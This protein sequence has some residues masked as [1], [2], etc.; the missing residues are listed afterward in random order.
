[1]LLRHAHLHNDKV[2]VVDFVYPVLKNHLP[3]VQQAHA[4]L[5]SRLVGVPVAVPFHKE[6]VSPLNGCDSLVHVV[7]HFKWQAVCFVPEEVLQRFRQLLML[8][9]SCRHL[10]H[11]KAAVNLCLHQLRHNVSHAACLCCA[12]AFRVWHLVNLS[13]PVVK[14]GSLVHAVKF[15]LHRC[16]VSA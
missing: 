1:M 3:R 16:A 2:H 15:L 7:Q 5:P 8:L 9:P 10:R 14:G 6:N 12:L 11:G 13:R 4:K